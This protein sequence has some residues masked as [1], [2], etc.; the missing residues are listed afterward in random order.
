MAANIEPWLLH[1]MANVMFTFGFV[2]HQGLAAWTGKSL[3]ITATSKLQ[4]GN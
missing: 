2:F 3:Q 4:D 1:R